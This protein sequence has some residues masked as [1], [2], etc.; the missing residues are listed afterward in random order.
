M[1][2]FFYIGNFFDEF[3]N[4]LDDYMMD[5]PETKKPDDWVEEKRI[6]DS[7]ARK[8]DDLS[9]SPKALPLHDEKMPGIM[10]GMDQKDRYVGAEALC[11]RGVLTLKYPIK[12]SVV[13][14]WDD[15]E[16]VTFYNELRNA[17]AH[18]PNA[19]RER[20]THIMFETFSVLAMYVAIRAMWSLC[21]SG[22]TTGIVMDSGEGEIV[23]MSKETQLHCT[24]QGHGDGGSE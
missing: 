19:Y 4:L 7:D 24:G 9:F 1:T 13:T 23:K 12:H 17:V 20:T 5:D 15:M 11:K 22:R 16:K 21:S 8:P 2:E 14:H 10:V 18:N 3:L 6:V